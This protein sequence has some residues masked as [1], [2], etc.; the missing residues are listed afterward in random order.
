M[1]RIA[2]TPEQFASKAAQLKVEEGLELSGNTGTLSKSGVTA[3]YSYDGQYL[4][5]TIT[6]KPF[7][8]SERYCESKLTEWLQS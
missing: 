1:I 4:S 8:V 2:L 3:Q 6:H 7:L 5:V